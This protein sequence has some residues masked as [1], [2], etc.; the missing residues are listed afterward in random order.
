MLQYPL[1]VV[2]VLSSVFSTIDID[3]Y[4]LMGLSFTSLLLSGFTTV[5]NPK[6]KEQ[7]ANQI[8]NEFHMISANICQFI[9]ENNKT[10]NELKAFSQMQ[11]ELIEFWNSLSPPISP[12]YIEKAKLQLRMPTR[13]ASTPATITRG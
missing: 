2:T 11:L 4:V 7:K 1:L 13:W 8:S 6:E 3:H 5:I 9:T 10:K 12:K